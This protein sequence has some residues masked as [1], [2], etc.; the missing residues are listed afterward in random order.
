MYIAAE[1]VAVA[2]KSFQI[3][4]REVLIIGI[5]LEILDQRNHAGEVMVTGNSQVGLPKKW[6]AG[7]N[8]YGH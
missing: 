7:C 3:L 1:V 8:V 2:G 5:L 6:L 4:D